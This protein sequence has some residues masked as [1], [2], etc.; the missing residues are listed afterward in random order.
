MEEAINFQSILIISL[1]A[2]VTPLII[3]F[4]KE[5]KYS[6]RCWRNICWNNRWKNFFKCSS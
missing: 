3:N 1:L 6:L 5:S 2:F 4:I